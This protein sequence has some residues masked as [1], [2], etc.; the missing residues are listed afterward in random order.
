MAIPTIAAKSA[1][2]KQLLSEKYVEKKVFILK[3]KLQSGAFFNG[4]ML[5]LCINSEGQQTNSKLPMCKE[6]GN[7]KY[8][9]TDEG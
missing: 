1:V 3:N 6:D 2:T 8:K 4:L 5:R 7:P 9:K